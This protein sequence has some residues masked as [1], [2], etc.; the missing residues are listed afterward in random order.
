MADVE[1]LG[2][3]LEK[4]GL[5][6]EKKAILNPAVYQEGDKTHMFYRAVSEGN[7]SSIGYCQLENKIEVKKRNTEPIIYPEYDYEKM[8][9]ED[10]R[11]TKIGDVYYMIYVAYDG[12][13]ARIAYATSKDLKNFKKHGIIS[14]NF[15]YKETE[16]YLKKSRLKD[17][18]FFFSSYI[19]SKLGDDCLLW[20]KDAFLL[21]QKIN[22]KFA[23]IHR[24]LPE[25]QIIFFDDFDQLRDDQF[26]K[27]YLSNLHNYVIVENTEWFENR[28]VGGGCPAIDTASGWLLI[29]HGVRQTNKKKAY[30]I[31]AAIL[32]KNDPCKLVAKSKEPI[33]MPE[34][35]WE[36]VGEVNNTIFPTGAA[37]FDNELYIYYGAADERISAAKIELD[38]FIREV[39]KSEVRN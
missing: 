4:T 36:L 18:Y 35:H 13:N 15:T 11:I 7:V 34:M 12:K 20:E 22:G 16:E 37:I 1:R 31:G 9:T 17:G 38:D 27:E 24:I 26:W 8:G 10:P 25:M 29:Y 30:S 23:L 21:P 19:R 33:L 5:D 6:F 39:I 3:I 28:N 32:D 14:P 2:I